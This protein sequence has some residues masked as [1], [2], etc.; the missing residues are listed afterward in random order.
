MKRTLLIALILV[1]AGTVSAQ[2][3]RCS[4][5][6]AELPAAAELFGFRLGMTTD[7]VKTHVPQ[8]AFGR[9]DEFA[10]SKT[11]I[12]PHFDSS[13]DQAKFTGVRSISLDFLDGRVTSLWL[14]YDDSFKWQS[15]ED[16][17]AGIS[18]SLRLP[19][20]WTPWK[21][22]G[23]R[24]RCSDFEITVQILGI[25]PSLRILDLNA[26]Q[27]LTARRE[28]KVEQDA[29]SEDAA[30]THEIVADRQQKIYYPDGCQPVDL[31]QAN[32]VI[33]SS[34]EEAEKSGYKPSKNCR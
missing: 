7:Q 14:G 33:F 32:R 22:R 28:A 12:N 2:D 6:L 20:S 19:N 1:C 16:F 18:Q 3:D 8:V 11:T 27:T 26:E 29:T 34:T 15:T 24:L 9:T 4:L 25:G 30:E 31:K 10:V 13:I 21:T 23:Q 5:K 17:V